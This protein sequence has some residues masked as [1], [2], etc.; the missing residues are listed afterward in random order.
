MEN[1]IPGLAG[2]PATK[3][4]VSFI[5]GQKGILEYRGIPIEQLVEYSNFL[6]TSY[7][8]IFGKLPKKEEYEKF[9]NDITHHRRIKFRII[10]MM[11]N[12]SEKAHPMEVL[13]STVSALGMFYPMKDV[14][15]EEY[16]YEAIV[17][18]IAKIPTIIAGWYRIR[19]GDEP[20]KPDDNLNF[21]EN[22]FYMMTEQVPDKRVA[23][24]FDKCLILHA[25][26]TMN[27]STFAALV[28]ASTLADPYTVMSS[29]LGA[30]SGPLH[31]GAN[32]KV[33]HMLMEI[34][35]PEKAREYIENKL[36]NKERIMG[37]GHRVYKTYDPRAKI[38][39]KLLK[40][41]MEIKGETKLYKIAKEVEKVAMEH[42][43]SKGIY[44]NVDFYSGIIYYELGIPVEFYTSI[45]AMA[46][47]SGWLAHWKEY[48]KENKLFRPSQIYEGSHNLPYIP[49][50]KR[51]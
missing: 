36:K 17:N 20:I 15:D 23:Q 3:S 14:L 49:L 38:L 40:E 50:D 24:I 7:L 1:L 6:E 27:A 48:I 39:E 9:V 47:I 13:Q 32:E 46:R 8:L 30:L 18:L 29:A 44:P 35:E 28:V 43:S 5:D 34:G 22:F 2:V 45:F 19:M 11:K 4:K 25:E 26:H 21:A 10:D 12:F 16:Q 33:F 31:G 51:K 42:L 41:L 37:F